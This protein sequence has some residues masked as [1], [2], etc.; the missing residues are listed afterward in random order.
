MVDIAHAIL[1]KFMLGFISGERGRCGVLCTSGTMNSGHVA[2]RVCVHVCTSGS[3]KRDFVLLGLLTLVVSTNSTN[4]FTLLKSTNSKIDGKSFTFVF[5]P[6]NL[7]DNVVGFRRSG[8][9]HSTY[10]HTDVSLLNFR[11]TSA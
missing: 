4:T 2:E 10:L 8:A 5:G 3:W 11:S 6:V 7:T 9:I 1:L